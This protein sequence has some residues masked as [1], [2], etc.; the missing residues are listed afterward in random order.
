VQPAFVEVLGA[1]RVDVAGFAAVGGDV[2]QIV[3][4]CS[5]VAGW[6]REA[7]GCPEDRVGG[8]RVHHRAAVIFK[9]RFAFWDSRM[10]RSGLT[11]G[12]FVQRQI[13][14]TTVWGVRN[15]CPCRHREERKSRESN[16]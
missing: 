8:L 16:E 9:R 10:D 2:F 7:A 11:D 4:N 14:D 12:R 15:D 5:L 3:G 13:G 1:D 6:K